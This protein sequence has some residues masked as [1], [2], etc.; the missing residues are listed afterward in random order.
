MCNDLFFNI[1]PKNITNKL[2]QKTWYLQFVWFKRPLT[3]LPAGN[4]GQDA[5][6]QRHLLNMTTQIN[7]YKIILPG[8]LPVCP[9]L[10]VRNA[11]SRTKLISKYERVCIID[12]NS[13][14][15]VIFCIIIETQKYIE[16]CP[17]DDRFLFYQH[18]SVELIIQFLHPLFQQCCFQ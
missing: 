5:H 13:S 6:V 9:E 12:K 16:G 2:M 3:R 18:N 7:S 8:R 11:L 10:T 1:G 17:D 4:I 15:F 14:A